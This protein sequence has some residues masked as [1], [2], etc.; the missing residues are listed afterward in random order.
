MDTMML[1]PKPAAPTAPAPAAPEPKNEAAG[2]SGSGYHDPATIAIAAPVD[3]VPAPAPAVA[4]PVAPVPGPLTDSSAM[5]TMVVPINQVP[6]PRPVDPGDEPTH[7][8]ERPRPE[9]G[10][11]PPLQQEE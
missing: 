9:P 1:P 8:T 2:D 11:W 4:T 3:P 7:V 6:P 5:E 10:A